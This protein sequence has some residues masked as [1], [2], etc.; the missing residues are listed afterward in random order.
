MP[1]I[2]IDS[3]SILDPMEVDLDGRTY[4]AAR[5]SPVLLER[6]KELQAKAG[7]L[8]EAEY[9]VQML[10][11]VFGVSPDEFREDDMEVLTAVAEQCIQHMG[12][13]KN[14]PA[15]KTETP[16]DPPPEGGS[17][18]LPPSPTPSPEPSAIPNS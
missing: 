13:R 7:Q 15:A 18:D 5:R 10:G 4:R 6:I 1:R 16:T 9:T 17:P 11:L 2:K 8:S 12:A 14:A 3:G